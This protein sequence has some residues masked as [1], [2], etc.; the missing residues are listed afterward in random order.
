[1][2]NLDMFRSDDE[3]KNDPDLLS[4]FLASFY[5]AKYHVRLESDYF[6]SN[7]QTKNPILPLL[8]NS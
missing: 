7:K 5:F 3:K 6:S 1:M 2:M 8:K 4:P